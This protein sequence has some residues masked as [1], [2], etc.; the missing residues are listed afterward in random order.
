MAYPVVIEDAEKRVKLTLDGTVVR[1]NLLAHNGTNWVQADAS[2]ASTNLYAQYIALNSGVSGTIIKGCRSCV[3]Y[4]EDNLNSADV[5]V[6]CSAT[7]GAITES[8]PTSAADVIQVVGRSIDAKRTKIDIAYPKEFEVWLP[9]S[10]YDTTNE[11]GLG[12]IDSPVWVGPG[13]DS[14]SEAVYFTS[15]FPSGVLSVLA[16]RIIYN[17]VAET[18][19]T[20]S[21]AL[22]SCVDGGTNTGDTGTAHSAAVPTSLANNALCYSNVTAMFDADALKAGYNFT[23]TATEVGASDGVLQVLGL[24]M[25]YL[26][27]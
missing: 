24:Y 2:D 14:L 7:A 19:I 8:R 23:V 25:R 3:L 5:P 1:G 9:P 4:D 6:Y 15:R 11:A 10:I 27:V 26:I 21:A 13:I 18:T 22:I 17:S 16:S 12:V 20:V